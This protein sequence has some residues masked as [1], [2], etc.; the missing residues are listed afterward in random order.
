MNDRHSTEVRQYLSL[1]QQRKQEVEEEQM[2]QQMPSVPEIE[3]SVLISEAEFSQALNAE[4]HRL[5]LTSNSNTE[6][7]SQIKVALAKLSKQ[8]KSDKPAKANQ[9]V[10]EQL[11][12]ELQQLKQ[13]SL[14]FSS[15]AE[16]PCS[17]CE[18]RLKVRLDV[19]HDPQII[20]LQEQIEN[21]FAELDIVESDLRQRKI[22]LGRTQARQAKAQSVF[23]VQKKIAKA[24]KY[25]DSLKF[26]LAEKP[27]VEEIMNSPIIK[28]TIRS[29]TA[30][31]RTTFSSE[32]SG[33]LRTLDH[34]DSKPAVVQRQLQAQRDN[35]T[36]LR[37]KVAALE[38]ELKIKRAKE[39]DE[40]VRTELVKKQ[41]KWAS[42]YKT[43]VEGKIQQ[44]R[45]FKEHEMESL[46]EH[47]R[48]LLDERGKLRVASTQRQELIK[49][50][51][52]EASKPEANTEARS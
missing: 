11:R 29:K 44:Y 36:M 47:R 1:I 23:K 3:P 15:T 41:H 38:Y 7:I 4:I 27:T 46:L 18:A 12:T 43:V 45:K 35:I 21:T 5:K 30:E 19:K 26:R 32:V 13:K 22:D 6:E 37:D 20:S 49:K 34:W 2:R 16:E 52:L 25:A 40:I 17:T 31:G 48:E 33:V 10:K 24:K 50:G 14:L 39:I 42:K 8:L 9:E 28:E 51:K